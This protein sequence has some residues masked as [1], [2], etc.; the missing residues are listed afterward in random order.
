MRF[1]HFPLLAC[2]LGASTALAAEGP[3]PTATVSSKNVVATL[4][5]EHDGIQPGQPLWVGLHLK[6]APTWH[7]YWR[8]PG[9]AGLPT[10]IR[11]RLPEGFTA[12]GIQWPQPAAFGVPP[13]MSYGYEH[14]VL[15]LSEIR[16]PATLPPGDVRL[17][18]RLDWLECQ[19]V[20][21]PGKGDV[22]LNLPVGRGPAAPLADWTKAFAR[23]RALLPRA[24]AELKADAYGHEK[25]L[26]LAV[27]G[28]AAPRKAYFF[29]TKGDVLQHAAP[30]PLAATARGFRLELARAANTPVPTHLDGVL[31]ADGRA[32]EV[33]VPVQAATPPPAA[34]TSS[35]AGAGLAV[36]LASA[37][38][39]G[40]ILNLMPCVLPVLSLKV[41]GFVRHGAEARRGPLRHALAF[42]A[43]VLLF[44][45]LLAGALLALRAGGQ[46]IG[47]GFQ[48]QSPAFVVVLS[49]LFLLVALNL[50]GVFEVGQS[51]TAAGNLAPR[52]TGLG[53]SFGSGALA[54]VVA[55]P[56]TAPFMGSALGFTLGQ[57][58]WATLLVFTSLGLGMAAPY[59]VL[60]S[61]P[62]LLRALPRP[63]RWM[64]TL[65]QAMGFPMLATV[66]FLAWVFGRQ[67][68]IDALTMMLGALLLI[69]AGAWVYG[70]GAPPDAPP[71][72]RLVS[73]LAAGALVVVGFALGL[74]QAQAAPA[75][76]PAGTSS[77]GDWEPWSEERLAE[78]RAAGTP[79]LVDFTADWCLTCQVNERV[80]LRD[81]AVRE[82][83]ARAGLVVLRADWTRRDERITRALLAHGRQGVPLYVLY[84]RGGGAEPR[85]LPAVLTPGVVLRALDEG[86]SQAQPT[87]MEV[88]S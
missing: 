83:F 71:R 68:S 54:T 78:L 60:A 38:L 15:L 59:V 9:D 58:G 62:R 81:A 11:W 52:S 29:P 46:Q 23:A 32:F 37:F 5:A 17:G 13:L 80:V 57:P 8:N 20:C 12:G 14:E 74:A 63:G 76:T 7:T 40:L 65:K 64:D 30:Q 75:G 84:G 88:E 73:A 48:L 18:A 49:G 72:R 34:A 53:S 82:R 6:M 45:W 16:T 51:L 4:V 79:V 19:E 69:A 35:G 85:L 70:R 66:V 22:E 42:A 67:T 36:A 87:T 1:V 24:A 10:R 56:C 21:L 61:S 44:F 26:T 50:F 33:A 28:L 55:T 41:M 25:G 77:T 47:W 39:G 2:I 27:A 86:L 43:G 31:V 3:G